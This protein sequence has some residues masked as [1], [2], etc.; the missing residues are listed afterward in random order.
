MEMFPNC[1][2][3]SKAEFWTGLRPK[4]PDSVPIIAGPIHENLYLNTGHGTLGWT[5]SSGS[6][7]VISDLISHKKPEITLDGLGPN[8]F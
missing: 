4:T 2:D 1:G 6:G 8:R 5:M 7:K 3:A